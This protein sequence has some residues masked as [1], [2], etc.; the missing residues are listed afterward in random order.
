MSN[1]SLESL[2]NNQLEK[3]VDTSFTMRLYFQKDTKRSKSFLTGP[4]FF[5]RLIQLHFQIANTPMIRKEKKKGQR[6]I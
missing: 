3:F 4:F 6:K 2:I 1:F 5:Q